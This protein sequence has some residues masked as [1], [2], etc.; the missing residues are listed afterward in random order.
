MARGCIYRQ[1]KKSGGFTWYVKYRTG[2]GTQVKRAAGASRR[3]AERA[4]TAALASVDR[5]EQRTVSHRTLET[6][7]WEWLEVK[8]PRIEPAT[9]RDYRYHLEKRLV[10]A[11][12]PLKLRAITRPRIEAYVADLAAEGRLSAKTINDS[13]IPLRQI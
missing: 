7:A 12:G 9:Y 1:P 3:E 8:R 5:G 10:P 11:F 13:L 4:L 6:E 2:D